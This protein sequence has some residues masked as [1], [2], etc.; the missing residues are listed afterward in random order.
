MLKFKMNALAVQTMCALKYNVVQIYHSRFS[1]L[2]L[3]FVFVWFMV[4]LSMIWSS[5]AY[6]NI[7][8]MVLI[9]FTTNHANVIHILYPK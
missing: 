1:K 2:M 5:D 9:N 3:D 8:M 4:E 7:I 6:S